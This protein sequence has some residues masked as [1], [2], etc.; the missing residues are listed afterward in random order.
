MNI[1]LIVNFNEGQLPIAAEIDGRSSMRFA[2]DAAVEDMVENEIPIG[3]VVYV[4]LGQLAPD[5]SFVG[6]GDT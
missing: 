6:V 3:D 5:Q 4:Y 1:P 2:D